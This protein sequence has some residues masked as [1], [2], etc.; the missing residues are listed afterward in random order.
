MTATVAG[1]PGGRAVCA[2]WY[3]RQRAMFPIWFTLVLLILDGF[4]CIRIIGAGH[5]S[6]PGG[7]LQAPSS[8]SRLLSSSSSP[9]LT[10]SSSAIVAS[11]KNYT[12]EAIKILSAGSTHAMMMPHCANQVPPR[13]IM[14]TV[15]TSGM[16]DLLLLQRAALRRQKKE[17]VYVCLHQIWLIVCLDDLCMNM[18][19][20][21]HLQKCVRYYCP[22]CLAD[23][24]TTITS[25]ITSPTSTFKETNWNYITFF[26]WEL[27]RD[28][29]GIGIQ[30]I[31][32]IDVDVLILRNPFRPTEGMI[33]R[34]DLL[35]QVEI[36]EE[37][38]MCGSFINSGLMFI[39]N[40]AKT[41][42]IIDRM[43]QNRAII[44]NGTE[45]EQ[46]VLH[47]VVKQVN[48]T[49][50]ALPAGLFT[51]HCQ[52][53]HTDS[54]LA[55]NVTSYHA[56]CATSHED[57]L[58]LLTHFLNNAIMPGWTF[59]HAELKRNYFNPEHFDRDAPKSYPRNLRGRSKTR[60]T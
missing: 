58:A 39:E 23:S 35:H 16:F 10:S 17:Y 6:G 7:D 32:T 5:S 50:C 48:A 46:D 30:T 2:S 49:K 4:G 8:E 14:V 18:C 41:L 57:K 43:F 55:L 12:N 52:F 36:E 15:S 9:S 40:T 22:T 11:N 21:H 20:A 34:Y 29:L 1:A 51:G 37:D 47:M 56:H 38:N 31:L 42:A 60:D 3:C 24:P 28:A 13:S 19:E 54:A 53:A 44:L 26:K 27:I 33:H 45:M 25:N 59:N